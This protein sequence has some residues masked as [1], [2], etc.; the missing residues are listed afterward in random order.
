MKNKTKKSSLRVLSAL[1]VLVLLVF[2]SPAM[3]MAEVLPGPAP[4]VTNNDTTNRVYGM[5]TKMEYSLDPAG[6][7]YIYVTYRSTAFKLI[8][9]SGSHV[10][11]VRYRATSTKPASQITTLIFTPNEKT[12]QPAPLVTN[13][14]TTNR[15]Y[16]MTTSMEYSL[17][18]AAYVGYVSTTFN[19]I[20]F[21][22]DHT[23]L[24]RYKE[25]DTK[26][27]SPPT[28]LTFTTNP[29]TPPAPPVTNDDFANTVTGMTSAME[30]RLDDAVTYS[31]YIEETFNQI[32]FAGDHTLRVRYA[33]E[34]I[35]PYGPDT[36]LVFTTNPV[37]TGKIVFTFDDGWLDT[38]TDAYPLMESYGFKGTV[39]VNRDAILGTS[40]VMMRI[41][42]VRDL[43]NAGWDISNHTTNHSN[44]L[45]GWDGVIPTLEEM[46]TVYRDNQDWI[47]RDVGARGA[48]HVAYPSGEYDAPLIAELK[49]LGVMTARYVEEANQPTPVTNVENYYELPTIPLESD[50]EPL[51]RAQESISEAIT[52]GSTVIFMLHR[53]DE[54][55][56]D[57]VL[58]TAD[59]TA[60]AE[61]IKGLGSQVDVMTI[62]EWYEQ[63][64]VTEQTPGKPSVT[65]DD[66]T[67]V[68]SG[69]ASGM[70][71]NLDGTGYVA[72]NAT[73][74]ANLDLTGYHTMLV[75]WAAN[76]GAPSGIPVLLVFTAD[77]GEAKVI[78][79]FLDGYTGQR[80]IALDV[81]NSAGFKGTA[82][83]GRNSILA[84]TEMSVSDLQDLYTAGWDISNRTADWTPIAG[85]TE[86]ELLAAYGDNQEWLLSNGWTRGAYH[87]S[88]IGG[89]YSDTLFSV[90]RSLGINTGLTMD[91]GNIQTPLTDPDG[92][93]KLPVIAVDNSD[94]YYINKAKLA[95]DKAV[96]EGTTVVI[97]I[98]RI[99][100]TVDAADPSRGWTVS[101]A[102]LE[103]IV[104]YAQ[105]YVG[106]E[107][108]TNT[109]MSE[110]YAAQKP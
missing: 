47:I 102:A 57:L 28:T 92:F 30:Y 52:D 88:Y 29:V 104:N 87:A 64:S 58:T 98:Q 5:T 94:S 110:W 42:Q 34:G 38:W 86:A 25:T 105:T 101:R 82:Y 17:D 7:P 49:K 3:V 12:P 14:D 60:I 79:A 51:V 32:D 35:N 19:L 4:L 31:P 43:Y 93:Y 11:Y 61:Y 97:S 46:V 63:A 109:T 95:I 54:N 65:L 85:K 8:D 15:V 89:G 33:A 90:L 37:K 76:G 9:F 41:D 106:Q 22:G 62:S 74:F 75:R 45:T 67:N 50:N 70:E 23:L 71:Y 91:E 18:G 59:F 40:P 72:Y 56:G 39:Y 55:E 66:D 83:V 69:M 100:E 44:Y 77:P 36:V 103:D 99:L 20:N 26:L 24:V 48:Y 13:N 1:L 96:F 6:E 73:D 84:A 81:L 80:T 78:F 108:L 68:V 2:A 107:K 16:G 21:A 10:L 27:A 53:V